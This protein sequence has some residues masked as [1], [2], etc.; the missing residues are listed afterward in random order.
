MMEEQSEPKTLIS[1]N[2]LV[3]LMSSIK[4]YS[5]IIDASDGEVLKHLK[6]LFQGLTSHDV[7]KRKGYVIAVNYLLNQYRDRIDED[8]ALNFIDSI[9]YGKDKQKTAIRTGVI[10]KILALTALIQSKIVHSGD[11]IL[12]VINEIHS[13]S[14]SRP[15]MAPFVHTVLAEIQ[16]E[17]NYQYL[18]E[19]MELMKPNLDSFIFI[20]KV[21]NSCPPEFRQA[22][23]PSFHHSTYNEA[24]AKNISGCAQATK[25]PWNSNVWK[26]IA[27]ETPEDQL[28]TFW[29]QLIGKQIR[30]TDPTGKTNIS[31]IY[32]IKSIL[33]TL[34]PSC[35]NII[36][37]STFIRMI[38]SL[39]VK[40]VLQPQIN[41]F[42]TFVVDL[43]KNKP[44]NLP[45]ILESFAHIDFRQPG[46]FEFHLKLYGLCNAKQLE[47][48]F[49]KVKNFG[50][51]D[52]MNFKQRHASQKFS[53]TAVSKFKLDTLRAVF[54]S[55]AKFANPAFT[56]SVFNY[57][58]ETW[59]DHLT[60]LVSDIVQFDTNR[61]E[62]A[63]TLPMLANEPEITSFEACYKLYSLCA[64]VSSSP[65]LNTLIAPEINN[66]APSTDLIL[67]A[68][69]RV[70]DSVLI[71]HAFKTYLKGIIPHIPTQQL[72]QFFADYVPLSNTFSQ[73]TLDIFEVVI[74]NSNLNYNAIG[75]LFSLFCKTVTNIGGSI[76]QSVSKLI[77][78]VL[79]KPPTN[80]QFP[81]VM[82]SIFGSFGGLS[83][84]VLNQNQRIINKTFNRTM[85]SVIKAA[86]PLSANWHKVLVKHLDNALIDFA[87][88]TNQHFDEDFFNAFL[89]LP[90]DI[91]HALFP[92]LM[93]Q[94]PNVKR[95]HRRILLLNMI[96]TIFST[97]KGVD[98]L[99]K[100]D[101]EFNNCVL[102]LLNEPFQSKEDEKKLTKF[103]ISFTRWLQ[104]MEKKRQSSSHVNI[105]DIRRKLTTI[106]NMAHDQLLTAIKQC[107][108][109]LQ[110]VEGQVHPKQR[111]YT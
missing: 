6:H 68:I 85:S 46:G 69:Q 53:E 27:N 63:A 97:P 22:L 61:V 64:G 79:D 5:E 66:A 93:K 21:A 20:L 38:N 36:I 70:S 105:G 51:L 48:S 35:Y 90:D 41:D 52:L 44:E 87:F 108:L 65:S 107:L 99:L 81:N 91:P 45:F 29:P 106:Q 40:P 103:I 54:I 78:I 2:D 73:A 95:I 101:K 86:M 15:L 92:I 110:R 17:T 94:L 9:K 34:K 19:T 109:A 49:E 77:K 13:V 18:A 16:K 58:S 74:Q 25:Q 76:V 100:Y 67:M 4:H 10:A 42:L 11:K 12:Y 56:L 8:E 28:L 104:F 30:S 47:E 84:K 88:K 14:I 83:Q 32:I 3:S 33:P 59:K 37:S 26:L 43:A 82:N 98:V 62:G 102:S 1:A 96:T 7:N 39:I 50:D 57:I 24:T 55:S 71:V 23:P 80:F 111:I 72:E 60:I 75:P 89:Q 31:V